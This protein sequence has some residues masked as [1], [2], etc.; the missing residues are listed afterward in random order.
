[1]ATQELE[2]PAPKHT[3]AEHMSPDIITGIGRRAI[4]LQMDMAESLLN[5]LEGVSD[6]YSP[7]LH[8]ALVKTRGDLRLKA[9]STNTISHR[10]INALLESEPLSPWLSAQFGLNQVRHGSLAKVLTR[11]NRD[12]TYKVGDELFLHFLE[13][14]N[15]ALAKTQRSF[16][17]GGS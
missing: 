7:H 8:D 17:G 3:R 16:E 5:D 1:M 2:G 13:W 12:G 4:E 6:V 9:L 15:H 11:K 14:H 10:Q